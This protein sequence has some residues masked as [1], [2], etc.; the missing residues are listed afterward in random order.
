MKTVIFYKSWLG[1]TKKYAGWLSESLKS[2]NY[3]FGEFG[4]EKLHDADTVVVMSGT[5]AAQMPLVGF[6]K[7][8]WNALKGKKIIV[9]A[10]GAAPADDEQS[11]TSY[12]LIPEEIRKEI[13][14]YKVPGK[15]FKVNAENVKAGHLKP[16]I[17]KIKG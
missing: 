5:Y 11:K 9:V 14:Y 7:K 13:S 12:E 8:N 4:T 2:E 1:S 16:I 3:G 10:V 6:L 15:L 17:D